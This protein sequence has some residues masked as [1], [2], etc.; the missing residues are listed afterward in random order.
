M[1]RPSWNHALC[2]PGFGSSKSPVKRRKENKKEGMR[3]EENSGERERKA[4]GE[5]EIEIVQV[6]FL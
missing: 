1:C 3:E 2:C 5:L 6:R 4:G